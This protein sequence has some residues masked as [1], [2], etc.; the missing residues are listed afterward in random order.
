MPT[1][2]SISDG[3]PTEEPQVVEEP[4]VEDR[5]TESMNP[6]VK[7][8]KHNDFPGPGLR[9]AA[10]GASELTPMMATEAVEPWEYE[11][12]LEGKPV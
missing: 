8:R 3:F 6:S 11:G 10:I 7:K 4:P 1:D 9:A 5:P 2:R 12:L